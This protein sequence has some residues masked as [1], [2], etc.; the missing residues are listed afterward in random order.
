MTLRYKVGNIVDAPEEVLVNAVNCVGTMGAG[1]ALAFKQRWPDMFLY[2]QESCRSG[3]LRRGEID[4]YVPEHGPTIINA[5]TKEHWRSRSK[6]QD[7]EVCVDSILSY[8]QAVGARSVAL[9]KLGC[10]LGGLAWDNVRLI[11]E[12]VLVPSRIDF[13]VYDLQ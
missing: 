13:V 9:P 1:V 3:E 6:I 5:A 11:Y 12:E 7:I 10:G 8:A 2:Y 4:V